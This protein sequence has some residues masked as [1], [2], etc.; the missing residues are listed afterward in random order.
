M[1]LIITL[2]TRTALTT[3]ATVTAVTMFTTLATLRAFAALTTGWTL[4]IAL[5]LLDEYTVR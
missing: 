1:E 4:L 2:R 3:V 5:W